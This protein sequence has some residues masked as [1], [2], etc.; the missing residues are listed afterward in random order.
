MCVFFIIYSIRYAIILHVIVIVMILLKKKKYIVALDQG[1]SA[2]RAIIFD[3][4][5][6]V[7]GIARKEITQIYPKPGWVEHDP[8]EIWNTQ[9]DVFFEVL[10]K[11]G[12]CCNQI[13]GIGVTNQ[14][15]TIVVWNKKD[16][17]P[18]YNAI[19]WQC[20]RTADFCNELISDTKLEKYVKRV[21]GLVIDPYF[22]GTKIKWILDFV[23]D[24]R[25]RAYH[26]ELLCGTIDSWIIWKM[27]NGKIHITDYTNASRTMLFNIHTLKWDDQLLSILDIPVSMLPRV[28]SS[29]EIYGSFDIFEGCFSCT[30]PI[31]GI[32]GDQQAAL[33]GQLCVFP[34]MSNITYGTGCFL[35]T[36]IG[37]HTIQSKYGLLTTIACGAKGELNYALEGT[38][39]IGGSIIQWLRDEMKLIS[40]IVDI[41]YFA[42]KVKDTHGVY[43]VPAFSGLAT[44][45]W[46]PHVRG[47]IFGITR[48]VNIYHIIRA[49]LEAIA[50]QIR[51]VVE[52][53]QVDYGKSF[54]LIR[55]A[56]GM[57]VSDFLM[58]CQ[59]DILNINIEKSLV[60]EVSA[61]GVAYLSGLS[62]GFWKS[63]EEIC[64]NS[65][66]LRCKF[67]PSVQYI[68][69]EYHYNCWKNAVICT[70]L[71]KNLSA[72]RKQ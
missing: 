13:S 29:S 61:L 9:Y 64:T 56:G 17:K 12:I 5:A 66:F 2:S 7:I 22:S 1:T 49:T 67:S 68:E 50:F 3:Y 69:R 16:G 31:S 70:R 63:F 26:G 45:F 25:T 39:F 32:A 72:K 27:T 6:N 8:M 21:T 30:I 71:W 65:V 51:D 24:S 14:R 11:T 55:V 62:V 42:R 59:S 4:Y 35:L 44:P 18:I 37:V 60:G 54:K 52:V 53:M 48:G 28:C 34:G 58:Q 46:D 15:E 20:R 40:D 47:S 41:E 19:V 36:N 33:Y 23:C 57:V 10:R 38:V 43:V